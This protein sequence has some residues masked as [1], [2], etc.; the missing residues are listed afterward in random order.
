MADYYPVLT[1]AI[2]ALPSNDP[3]AR[4]DLFARARTIVNEQLRNGGRSAAVEVLR[5][6]AALEAAIGR[7]EAEAR[8]ARLHANGKAAAAPAGKR[9]AIATPERPVENTARS[10]SKILQAVQSDKGEP[11]GESHRKTV[12]GSMA[13]SS[14]VKSAATLTMEHQH[15][16]APSALGKAPS[17]LGTMLFE[18]TYVVAALAFTAVTYIR[19]IVWVYQGVISY[20]ILLGV[21]ALTLALFIAPPVIIF[22]RTSSL[23]TIDT[24]WRFIHSTS[25]RVL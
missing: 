11:D 18:L 8:S 21:M 4:R 20:P 16:K 24:V 15:A 9:V 6:Q 10:L 25:R 14:A 12:N 3:Q 2:S 22:R 17:S 19:C 1:R 23:P 5:E 13:L 7:I